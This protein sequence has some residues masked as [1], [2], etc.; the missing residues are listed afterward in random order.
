ML[1]SIRA[2][3]WRIVHFNRRTKSEATLDGELEF[4]LQMEIEQNF[5]QGMNHEEARRQAL[6]ALGGLEQTMEECR[7]VLAVRLLRDL[8][9]D[10]SY[11]LRQLRHAPG[12]AAVAVITLALGIG[13]NTAIFTA[14]NAVLLRPLPF[15]NADRMITI[16]EKNLS[17]EGAKFRSLQPDHKELISTSVPVLRE[18]QAQT[19]LFEDVGAYSSFPA[20]V[21]LTGG[22]EPEEIVAGRVT[23]NFFSTLGVA[24]ELGR[25]FLPGEDRLG[26][27]NVVVLSH[28]LWQRRLGADRTICGRPI[29]LNGAVSTVAGVMPPSFPP[30]AGEE[31][32]VPDP[33][34]SQSYDGFRGS[35]NMEVIARLKPGVSVAQAQAVLTAGA[36]VRARLFPES[37]KNYATVI[38]PLREYLVGD[39]RGRLVLLSAATLFVILIACANVANMLLARGTVHRR[40][41]ALRAALGAGCGRLVR[42]AIA[43]TMLLALL[44]GAAGL[45]IGLWAVSWLAGMGGANVSEL[46]NLRAD[47]RVFCF[48]LAASVVVGLLTALVPA[49]QASKADVNQGL[50]ESAGAQG[51][52]AAAR[53]LSGLLV[54]AEVACALILLAGTGLMVNTLAHLADVSLGF[55]SQ[56][57][58]TLRLTLP[59][60]K[61]SIAGKSWNNARARAFLAG[62]LAQIKAVPGVR[63]A[64][65]VYPLPF[66]KS[67]EGT[68]VS[69]E[70]SP[71]GS[72]LPTHYRIGTPDYFRAMKIPLVRGRIF[73]DH[74]T[75]DMPPV[76]VINETL[77]RQLWPNQDPIGKR[78]QL[79]NKLQEVVGV[80]GDVR[81]LRPDLPSGAESYV[82]RA[83]T[84]GYSTMFVAVR[85]A[86]DPTRAA[87]AV[88]AAIW[89]VDK[90]QPVQDMKTMDER[91][92][93]F[94]ALRR[95]YTLLLG[96]FAG[97]AVALS[98]V[99][100]Y[101]VISYSVSQ[102]QNEIG[103]RMAL[104]AK[105]GEV[106]R[107]VLRQGLLLVAIGVLLGIAGALATNRALS[108][109]LYGVRPTDPLTLLAVSLVLAAVALAACFLPAHRAT[110]IDPLLALRKE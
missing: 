65:A 88:R 73:T 28:S 60:Y 17:A 87:E 108:N 19:D 50:K 85:T 57:L 102:R 59:P 106:M 83:Q 12:F 92:S 69:A 10:L 6:I 16:W 27:T 70:G 1:A 74:D 29:M 79:K 40:E 58:L 18:W 109:M 31:A 93:G 41:M 13:A 61:Y 84:G 63:E 15:G 110:R 14:V 24:P 25:G 35:R 62:A 101:G 47:W 104:G 96:I 76:V 8:V 33:I 38:V 4:H 52:R 2:F 71:E 34:D 48:A 45:G 81:H 77:A 97:I 72:D 80:V 42:Q 64:G 7:D 89:A 32:W 82:P 86:G 22:G 23:A 90:D 100:I 54:V 68:G 107:M 43:E 37:S 75:A 78:V 9:Q 99:G 30:M 11:G 44:G 5:R 53:R 51:G 56:N 55:S 26:R 91:L 67:Q 21:V 49:L 46:G 36:E 94:A 3:L 66:S 20:R 95:I 98:A 103:I 105:P 39:M